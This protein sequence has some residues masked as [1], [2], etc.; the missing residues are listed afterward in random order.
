M[1]VYKGFLS[2][3]NG[4][5]IDESS[6][7]EVNPSEA[8]DVFGDNSDIINL[9][10][11]EIEFAYCTEFFVINL[12]KK[13]TLVDIDKLKEMPPNQYPE[14]FK[15]RWQEIK[16]TT[17]G[18]LALNFFNQRSPCGGTKLYE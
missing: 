17:M 9:D 1:C 4:E 13:T 14:T 16:E 12:K 3:L 6:V 15:N 10:L 5:E 8:D 7:Y 11:G 2:V 18:N